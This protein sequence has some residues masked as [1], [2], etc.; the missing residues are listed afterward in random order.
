MCGGMKTRRTPGLAQGVV[1]ALPITAV[2]LG[3]NPLLA[4]VPQLAAHFGATPDTAGLLQLALLVPGVFVLLVA[5]VAGLLADKFGRR[6]P[7]ISAFICYALAGLTPIIFDDVHTL[8]IAR[9]FTGISEAFILVIGSV[10]VCDYYR[11]RER[12]RW[13]SAQTIVTNSLSLLSYWIGT[14]LALWFGWQGPFYLAAHG[15]VLAIL[16]A[17]FVWEPVDDSHELTESEARD[18]H[19]KI[20]FQRMLGIGLLAAIGSMFFFICLTQ[21]PVVL[22]ELGV[23]DPDMMTRYVMLSGVGVPIGVAIYWFFSQLDVGKLLVASFLLIGT[24]FAWM[25]GTTTPASYLLAANLQQLGCGLF[26]PS[27]IIWAMDDL[28][29]DVRGRALGM[30]HAMFAVGPFLGIGFVAL[31]GGITGNIFPIFTLM[32]IMC[33]GAA[34][35][36]T[37]AVMFL[38]ERQQV[39]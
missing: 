36:A 24:G 1:L 30:F 39:A 22:T 15:F 33:F 5:P 23:R 17:M 18:L 11:D 37:F 35:F 8:V 4:S 28:H 19:R 27:M 10:L 16:F 29:F 26:L 14:K 2:V 3:M 9:V 31:F 20:P 34:C 25:G 38:M 13:F 32:S 21:T 7:L 12:A 6:P